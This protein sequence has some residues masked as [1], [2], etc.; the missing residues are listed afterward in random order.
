MFLNSSPFSPRPQTRKTRMSYFA[1]RVSYSRRFL[2]EVLFAVKA[3]AAIAR[4]RMMFA[5]ISPAWVLPLA[6]R[7]SI[8][9]VLQM[10]FRFRSRYLWLS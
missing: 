6:A 3:F 1:L 5:L 7:T 9:P 8:V 10:L 2:L 4:Q